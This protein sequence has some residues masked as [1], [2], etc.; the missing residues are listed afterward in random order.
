M[1]YRVELA[2]T[3][4]ADIRDAT[5]WLRNRTS[6]A[7]VNKWLNGLYKAL[8]ALGNSPTRCPIAA[9]DDKF[10]EEIREHLYGQRRR[11]YRIIFTIRGDTV[12]ILYVRHGARDELEP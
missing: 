3:A 4:K 7:A 5:R 2:E 12:F 10:P 8:N 11:K 1:T 6:D 9:E